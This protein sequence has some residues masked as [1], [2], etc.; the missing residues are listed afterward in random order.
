VIRQRVREITS[1]FAQSS[2]SSNIV[3][4]VTKLPPLPPPFAASSHAVRSVGRPS[5]TIPSEIF[6]RNVPPPTVEFKL[7]QAYKRLSTTPQLAY[8]LGLLNASDS[9]AGQLGPDAQH[10][11]QAIE[12]DTE[13]QE[14]LRTMA[15]DVVRAFKRDELKDAKVIAEVVYLAPVLTKDDFDLLLGMFFW[16]IEKSALLNTLQVEGLARLIQE[17][18]PSY[19]DADNL[20][21]I[22]QLLSAHLLDVHQQSW[23]HTH[24]LTLAISHVLDAMADAKVT[25][26]DRQKIH[27]PLSN[28]LNELKG[29]SDPFLVYQAAYGYQALM[30]VP[31]NES[32][33]Q[34][35]MRRT[36]KV[37]SGFAGIASAVK[38]LDLAKFIENLEKIQEELV[39]VA[40]IIQTAYEGVTSL[41]ESGQS[42]LECL[43]ESFDIKSK[44]AWYSALRGADVLVRN[45]ALASFKKLVCEAPC[46]LDVPFQ[47]GVCQRLGAIAANPK[48]DMDSRRGAVAFLGEIYK[49]D[50]VWGRQASIKKWILN[51]LMQLESAKGTSSQST[52]IAGQ[53]N[54]GHGLEYVSIGV[55]TMN[56]QNKTFIPCFFF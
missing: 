49:N 55:R 39:G 13:E 56:S 40:E 51:I 5:F 43:K 35:A 9:L 28:Y 10:W 37:I 8:C 47:W 48:W 29:S 19:F 36:G 14:R 2:P 22:L 1:Q 53:W 42:F 45:G 20:V 54:N 16:G 24:Q 17:A 46:R 27:E 11:L 33:W 23:Y 21:K 34:S 15:T 4:V 12:K 41:A 32:M 7:P 38:G 6:A 31:D 25:G 52:W 26:L 18:N 30:C 44:K 50:E 3:Q